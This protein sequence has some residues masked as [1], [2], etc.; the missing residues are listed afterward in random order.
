MMAPALAPVLALRREDPRRGGDLQ[1]F[2]GVCVAWHQSKRV[3]AASAAVM[4]G[5]TAARM[6]GCMDA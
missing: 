5:C 3:S 2:S 1:C 4:H 6:H